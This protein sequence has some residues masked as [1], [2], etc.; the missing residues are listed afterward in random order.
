[1]MWGQVIF[2]NEAKRLPSLLCQ[3]V[4]LIAWPS[5]VQLS[6]F[7]RPLRQHWDLSK[8]GHLYSTLK[9]IQQHLS[10]LSDLEVFCPVLWKKLL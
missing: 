10:E 8:V 7:G 2:Y 4:S 5:A 1:M 3:E 9:E 6:F